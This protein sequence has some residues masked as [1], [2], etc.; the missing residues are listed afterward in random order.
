VKSRSA[1]VIPVIFDSISTFHSF[2]RRKLYLWGFKDSTIKWIILIQKKKG[3][4]RGGCPFY[5]NFVSEI[6]YYSNEKKYSSFVLFLPIVAYLSFASGVNG[7]TTLPVITPSV[8]D[9]GKW[10]SLNGETVTLNGNITIL[11]FSGSDILKIRKFV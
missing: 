3:I 2:N 5:F 4:R 9:L 8:P 10:E 7:F 1:V 11:G 6:F